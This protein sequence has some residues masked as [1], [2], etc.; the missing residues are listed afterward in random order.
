MQCVARVK[1]NFRYFCILFA[2]FT[3]T[4]LLLWP[5]V[6]WAH[7]RHE[8]VSPA[9]LRALEGLL[10]DEELCG[11]GGYRIE[12]TDLCTHGTDMSPTDEELAYAELAL[13]RTALPVT[14]VCIG[15]G[16]SG[17]RVQVLYVRASD[18]PDRYATSLNMIR[19][20]A[21][22][23]GFLYDAS[24]Y[25]TGGNRLVNYVVTPACEID[26]LAVEIPQGADA[27][28]AATIVAL[29]AL[30]Y[31]SPDRKY[32]IFMESTVYCGIA[33]VVNDTQPG[34]AHRSNHRTGYA[35]VD[36]SCWNV[37]TAAHELTHTLGG[38]QHSSPNSTGS[39]HCTDQYDVMCYSDAPYY[40]AVFMVCKDAEFGSLLDCNNDDYFHTNPPPGSYLATHWNVTDSDFLIHFDHLAPDADAIL[41][42]TPNNA[43]TSHRDEYRLWIEMIGGEAVEQLFNSVGFYQGDQLLATITDGLFETA[44]LPPEPGD[45]LIKAR[46]YTP[47]GTRVFEELRVTVPQK[48]VVPNALYL[49]MIQLN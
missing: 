17:K 43:N 22:D 46:L 39:W 5:E 10:G 49:P 3:V 26:V 14:T 21:I 36:R 40:P 25:V 32:L 2:V 41:R 38:V 15:D 27:N 12:G 19:R 48:A 6:A 4:A 18:R 20:I 34:P 13:D 23:V 29:S 42:V 31:N 33:T 28:L 16:Q 45:Y 11:P 44:W 30:G 24:A 47:E 37:V 1:I 7:K 8:M 35:R 9:G